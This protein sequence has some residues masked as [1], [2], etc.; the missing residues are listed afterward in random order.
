MNELQQS[1]DQLQPSPSKT[2][3]FCTNCDAELKGEFCHQCGQSSNNMIK[4]FGDLFL[5]LMGNMFG[6]DSKVKRSIIPLLLSPGKL[7]REYIKGKRFY[8]ILPFRFY[9]ISSLFF[10]LALQ[11]KTDIQDPDLKTD[12]TNIELSDDLYINAEPSPSSD[13]NTSQTLG[14]QI[15]KGNKDKQSSELKDIQISE[16]AF[17]NEFIKV[18]NEKAKQWQNNPK[19]FINSFY[20]LAPYM[21]LILIPIFAIFV[22]LFYLFSNRFYIEHLIFIFHNHCFLYIAFLTQFLLT[23]LSSLVSES[24]FFISQAISFILN[25]TSTLLWLWI[26]TYFFIATKKVY[27][28]GWG[29][30]IAKTISL[31]AIYLVLYGIG[32]LTVILIGIYTL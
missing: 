14:S 11:F 20:Q 6:Y 3:Q 1:K 22:K 23:Y 15:E 7:T 10:I 16:S 26:I 24:Q 30:T 9:L 17:I 18:V 32:L 12:P 8:Y 19:P 21:M 13:Q 27:Q 2:D 4:F 25:T 29:M 28:Q 5:E 31:S